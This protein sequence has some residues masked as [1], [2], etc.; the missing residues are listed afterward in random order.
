[1]P[2][3]KGR[4][5]KAVSGSI[6][7]MLHEGRDHDQAVAIALDMAGKKKHKLKRKRRH[8]AGMGY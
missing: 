5:K 3:R 6:R 8:M 7:T 2:L 4:S 1:M